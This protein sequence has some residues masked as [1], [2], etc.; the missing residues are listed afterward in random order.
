MQYA[1]K[2]CQRLGRGKAR[3]RCRRVAGCRCGCRC[4]CPCCLLHLPS[5]ALASVVGS[6][7]CGSATPGL[8]FEASAAGVALLNMP[9]KPR[10]T[11]DVMAGRQRQ[12]G[13]AGAALGPS[14]AGAGRLLEARNA[15][16]AGYEGFIPTG[17]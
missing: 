3:R 1:S 6:V 7:T 17:N 10:L 13:Q 2:H 4:G 14:L 12:A 9:T 16:N 11:L 15:A 5:P 8:S